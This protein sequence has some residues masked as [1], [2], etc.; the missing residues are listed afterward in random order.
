MISKGIL[1]NIGDEIFDRKNFQWFGTFLSYN[2]DI[3]LYAGIAL[4][5]YKNKSK[6]FW[7]IKKVIK[8]TL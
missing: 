1:S 8:L 4:S 6:Y 3:Y 5:I 2:L 7:K